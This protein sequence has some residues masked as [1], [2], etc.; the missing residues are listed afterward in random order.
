MLT[1]V[2]GHAAVTTSLRGSRSLAL[3]MRDLKC[4]DC[5]TQE[6]HLEIE[7]IQAR[8]TPAKRTAAV[9]FGPVEADGTAEPVNMVAT[10]RELVAV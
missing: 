6:C 3:Q 7:V 2:R 8:A 4:P 10:F 5:A 9:A 1:T